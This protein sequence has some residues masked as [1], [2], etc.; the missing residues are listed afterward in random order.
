MPGIILLFAPLI[1]KTKHKSLQQFIQ[2]RSLNK[3][4]KNNEDNKIGDSDSK[5]IRSHSFSNFQYKTRKVIPAVLG[6]LIVTGFVLNN[7]LAYNFNLETSNDKNASINVENSKIIETFGI[8]N[9]LV[10]LVPKGDIVKEQELISSVLNLESEDGTKIISSG[11]SMVSTGIYEELTQ[12]E[13]I[14]QF[15]ISQDI[16][17]L[18]YRGMGI[19]SAD[20]VILYDLLSYI[21]LNDT[22]SVIA[23]AKQENIDDTYSS[24]QLLFSDL[25][26]NQFASAFSTFGF[27]L[28]MATGVYTHMGKAETS[29]KPYEVFMHIYNN[30]EA[31]NISSNQTLELAIDQTYLKIVGLLSNLTKPE[32]IALYGLPEPVVNQAFNALEATSSVPVYKL[33]SFLSINQ[34]AIKMGEEI[35]NTL[36]SKWGDVLL[37]FSM[38]EGNDYSRIIFNLNLN[39]SDEKAF[40]AIGDVKDKVSKIY[41]E[42]YVVSESANL[43][44]IKNLFTKDAVVINLISFIAILILIALTFQSLTIPVLLTLTIQ[45]AIWIT[46]SFN[47]VSSSSV[48]FVCYL[49]VMCIQMGATVDY[50]ILI[51][52]RYVEYRK[53]FGRKESMSKAMGSSIMTILTSGS[54]LVIATFLVGIISNV[55]IISNLGLL[56]A[57]GCLI[58]ILLIIFALPQTLLLSDKL[59]EKTT[60]NAKFYD[61]DLLETN[62]E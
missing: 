24:I 59:I 51:T 22:V 21:M 42:Y 5:K 39:A 17:D 20:K 27:D 25:T 7:N 40:T 16:L 52:S 61:D 28:N 4:T 50:G 34:V 37:A 46:M 26:A 23:Q 53:S 45:G 9:S 13:I 8:Q 30:K 15:G 35:Q 12:A 56:L 43:L 54:I 49:V 60:R 47:V 19:N 11:Q 55:A 31:F 18:V 2:E 48:F 6:I 14:A 58:S 1:K 41:D 36:Q 38:F 32:V 33:I 29:A 10:V 57:R 62:K 3:K 44:E